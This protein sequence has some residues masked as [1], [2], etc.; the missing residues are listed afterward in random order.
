MAMRIA[1]V[2]EH[3]SPLAEPGGAECGG[4]NLYV[5]ELAT[6]LTRR[7]HE[8]TV[9]TRR[10]RPDLP[11]VVTAPG[12]YRVAH[13]PAGP[14]RHVPRD[15]LVPYLGEFTSAL[16][17][18]WRDRPPDVVHSHFW[19]SGM[20]SVL[21]ADTVDRPVVHT[22]HAL[23]TVKRRHQGTAD[24]SPP[25]RL[26]L[27]RLIGRRAAQ[28]VATCADEVE[29]LV[30]M[31]VPRGRITVVPC[32]VDCDLFAPHGF[33]PRG[34]DPLRLLSVGRLLPRKGFQD[35]IA[36]LTRLPGAGLVIAGGPPAGPE[37]DADPHCA[38]LRELAARLGV[39]ERVRFAGQVSRPVLA[40]LMRQAH[41]VLCV[42]WY[43]PFG[44]VAVEA[45]AAGTPVV[46]TDVGGLRDTVVHGL[47][48]EL[49]PPRQPGVLA[50]TVLRLSDDTSRQ[51]LGV[52]GRDRALSRYTWDRVASDLA[53]VY[54][55]VTV[56][57]RVLAGGAR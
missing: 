35:A 7:G 40:E 2:S 22:Y 48:G 47:T 16:V 52:A 32:G 51:N 55:R 46:A 9:H 1:M 28:V 41:L 29:E 3:A 27:E 37:L 44:L 6:A 33:R 34:D 24:T 45:M 12:G 23:G 21:A 4:Q 15:E 36:A 43:E 53:R 49:V 8:V 17:D 30:A 38:R 11:A 14:A 13:V 19:M 56:G 54:Q 57:S 25:Q 39:A 10:D 42:P 20:V 50:A 18:T 5:A 26:Q 31:G